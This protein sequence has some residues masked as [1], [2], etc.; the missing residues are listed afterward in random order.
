MKKTFYIVLI[1]VYGISFT[2]IPRSVNLGAEEVTSDRIYSSFGP[3]KLHGTVVGDF[4]NATLNTIIFNFPAHYGSFIKVFDKKSGKELILKSF[5]NRFK[6][7][8]YPT[9]GWIVG[10]ILGWGLRLGLLI[11]I[12]YK[13]KIHSKE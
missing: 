1:I 10:Q 8:S 9:S 12:A 13:I 3:A 4:F 5:S 7:P 6:K 11:F 2:P